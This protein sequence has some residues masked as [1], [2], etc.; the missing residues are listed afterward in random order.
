MDNSSHDIK[1]HAILSDD[2]KHLL[3]KLVE[4]GHLTGR[5]HD[6]IIKLG[7]TISDIEKSPSITQT[8]ILEALQFRKIRAR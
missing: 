3:A 5:S 4:D 8:H 1:K 2:S 7:Q 6:H